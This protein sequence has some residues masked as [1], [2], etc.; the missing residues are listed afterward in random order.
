[1][2]IEVFG[3]DTATG[4]P[5]PR[6]YRDHPDVWS[7]GDYPMDEKPLRRRLKANTTLIIGD[8]AE[9]VPGFTADAS[10]PPLG[11]AAFDLDLYSSTREALRVLSSPERRILHRVFLYFDDIRRVENHSFAGERLAISEFNA[12]NECVKIDPW[13]GLEAWHPFPDH[14]WLRQM[15]IAHDL[16]A[17]SRYQPPERPPFLNPL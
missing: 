10:R 11:F 9:T 3:F 14:F 4:L 6:D 1:V 12:E 8:A 7:A 17:I 13:H 15:F 5:P 2:H 16:E